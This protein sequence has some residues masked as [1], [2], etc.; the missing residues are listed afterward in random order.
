M[1]ELLMQQYSYKGRCSDV[2][3]SISLEVRVVYADHNIHSAYRELL[4]T[5]QPSGNYTPAKLYII[6]KVISNGQ[7]NQASL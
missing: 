7:L 1:Y 4:R 6:F 3:D 2:V 5:A